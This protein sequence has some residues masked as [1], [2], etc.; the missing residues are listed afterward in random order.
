[1]A[2]LQGTNSYVTIAQADTYFTDRISGGDWEELAT[3]EKSEALVT[4]T[5]ILEALQWKGNSVS[6]SQLLSFPRSGL[7]HSNSS[8]Y[9][10]SSVIPLFI[11]H[12]Q[13]ELAF[14]LWQNTAAVTGE[15]VRETTTVGAI[16]VQTV[17]LPKL[18][19][20]VRRL[21]RPYLAVGGGVLGRSS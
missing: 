21:I 20:T 15:Q 6:S 14:Y 1:M 18:P 5:N 2:L 3:E 12:A 4:A 10:D 7:W 9:L 8:T 17:P 19:T 13:F 11:M 16:T